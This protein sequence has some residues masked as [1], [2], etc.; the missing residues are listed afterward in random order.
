MVRVA[1]YEAA[2]LAVVSDMKKVPGVSDSDT[3][4]AFRVYSGHDLEAAFSL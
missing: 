3:H 2:A 1:G 4:L